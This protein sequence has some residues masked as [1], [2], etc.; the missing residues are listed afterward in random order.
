MRGVIYYD[1]VGSGW[2]PIDV[3]RESALLPMDG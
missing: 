3:Y 1:G 2:F